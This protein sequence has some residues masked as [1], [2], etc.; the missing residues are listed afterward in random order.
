MP[1]YPQIEHIAGALKTSRVTIVL[2]SGASLD[3]ANDI[4][5]PWRSDLGGM[6][7][8]GQLAGM[9]SETFGVSQSTLSLTAQLVETWRGT[10]DLRSQINE[11]FSR[12]AQPLVSHEFCASLADWRLARRR[13][14]D[15]LPYPLP[16]RLT[17]PL[18]VTTNYD[19][20][21]E[22]A[23]ISRGIPFDFLTYDVP[24]QSGD[25]RLESFRYDPQV[26]KDDVARIPF[27]EVGTEKRVCVIKIHGSASIRQRDSDP[28]PFVITEDD[29]IAYLASVRWDDFFPTG[30]RSHLSRCH[31]LFLGHSLTDWNL[32]VM[33]QQI[34]RKGWRGRTDY[35]IWVVKKH[36]EDF[37]RKWASS[38]LNSGELI[39]ANLSDFVPR[40]EE[41]VTCRVQIA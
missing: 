41:K 33:L 11:I 9:L 32:R 40:L 1:D 2:G 23:F 4:G 24:D 29:Y 15:K 20:L 34:T 21:L 8:A 38:A 17:C 28:P 18:F 12:R 6:P 13:P 14:E 16:T 10:D 27:G 22:D 7:S 36:V 3:P 35:K 31:Y 25:P 26:A 5:K 19:T 39:E 30:I 37:E